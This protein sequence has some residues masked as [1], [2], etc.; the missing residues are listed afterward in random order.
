M[1]GIAC[2]K[3]THYKFFK[4]AAN[5]RRFNKILVSATRCSSV[6][7][8]IVSQSKLFQRLL[9]CGERRAAEWFEKYWTSERGNWTKAHA[10]VGGTN[11]N[12]G[13]E[14]R[15]DGL[16]KFV[17]GN[18]GSTAGMPNFDLAIAK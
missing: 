9:D 8:S 16:K 11:N 18:N 6:A 2:Q 12:N 15:W 3:K 13:T 5:Y 4:D 14:G 10:G 7:L 1:A 17:C